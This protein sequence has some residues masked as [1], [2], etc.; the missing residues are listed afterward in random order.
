MRRK[1]YIIISIADIKK[2]VPYTLVTLLEKN[3]VI[4]NLYFM[5]VYVCK[6]ICRERER[7]RD[8]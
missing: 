8:L 6:Q 5:D 4:I 7:E 2:Y 3:T 1:D